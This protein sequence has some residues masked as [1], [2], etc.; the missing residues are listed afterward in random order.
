[1]RLLPNDLVLV[2][3][4]NKTMDTASFMLPGSVSGNSD[5]MLIPEF[6]NGMQLNNSLITPD[7]LRF[8]TSQKENEPNNNAET[9][10]TLVSNVF[11][12]IA[13]TDDNDWY[14]V[15]TAYAKKI[16]LRNYGSNLG[17]K[18]ISESDTLSIENSVVNT[19]MFSIPDSVKGLVY[20]VID[21]PLKSAGGYYEVTILR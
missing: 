17:L 8:R 15:N 13:T 7:T 9:A 2:A 3:N 6:E 16:R 19:N 20:I 18:V 21:T 12:S 1:M 4:L 10:D 11:G 14:V 5:Y